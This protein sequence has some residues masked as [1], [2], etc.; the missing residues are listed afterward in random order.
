MPRLL[1]PVTAASLASAL[2]GTAS[3]LSVDL[4][5]APQQPVYPDAAHLARVLAHLGTLPP[6]V[7]SWEITRLR[8]QLAEV[9]TGQRFLLQGG[10]CAESF[11]DCTSPVIANRMKVLL[12]MSLVLTYGLGQRVVRVGRYAGQF[13]KPRSSDVETRGGVTLPAYR[14]DIINGAPFTAEARTPDPD[15]LVRAYTKSALTLNF[16]RALVDGGFADLNHPELWEL[17]F[18]RH[19]P[20]A[21]EYHAIVARIHEALSF[22]T[23]LADGTI[24]DLARADFFTSHEALLLDYEAAFTRTVPRHA[25]PYNLSTHL[26]W[27]GL[28][29]NAPDGPHVAYAAAIGNPVAVKVG[30]TT[31]AEHVE[32]LLAR[33]DPQKTPGR[34]ALICR[35]GSEAV[36]DHLPR[37][38]ETVRR[39]GHPVVWVCDAMHGNTETTASGVKTRRFERIVSEIEQSFA[40]HRALGSHLGG[41]HLELTGENVTEC[42]GGARGLSEAD[43]TRDYRSHVDPRLNA[44]Q[45]LEVALAVVRMHRG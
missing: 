14:G 31:D 13:A 8:A 45:A 4:S 25:E 2:P 26:P 9:A 3:A 21:D 15:R 5:G 20:L 29:T 23:T 10:D 40:I 44:E 42:T 19:A 22:V 38:V 18:A 43:L 16:V 36:E 28:R 17:D 32:A 39:R 30:T 7:T 41:V 33:L 1:P 34:L 12:Q 24:P 27:I 35:F 6:L 37:L 11:A